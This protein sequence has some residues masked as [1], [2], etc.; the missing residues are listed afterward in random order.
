MIF[1][2]LRLIELV[3]KCR[4]L[5]GDQVNEADAEA[6]NGVGVVVNHRVA[7]SDGDEEA[8]EFI[9]REGRPA[10]C[11]GEGPLD[12]KPGDQDDGKA[13]EQVQANVL[14]HGGVAGHHLGEVLKERLHGCHWN[15]PCRFTAVRTR[16][17][18]R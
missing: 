12:S 17:W 13:A 4:G 14:E 10:A 1:C 5:V 16:S 11:G 8:R 2:A 7:E 9:E 18:R 6:G 15:L 3:G